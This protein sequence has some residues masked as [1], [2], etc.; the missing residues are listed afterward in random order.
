LEHYVWHIF[1][2]WKSIC[3]DP[4]LFNLLDGNT[5]KVL[6]TLTP[7]STS[8]RA[9]IEALAANGEIFS[10]VDRSTVLE[11]ILPRILQVRGRIPSFFTLFQDV[12][13]LE[14][15]VKSL[16]PLLPSSKVSFRQSFYHCFV[17][18]AQTQG[19]IKIQTEE[20]K[21]RFVQGETSL[22]KE[23]G[24]L[25]LFLAAMRDFPVLSQTAPHQSRGEKQPCKGSPEERQSSLAL[26]ALDLG[27]H[28]P[29]IQEFAER[30][31]DYTAIRALIHR[32]RP[33]EHYDIDIERAET[34]AWRLVEEIRSFSTARSICGNPEFS[35][36]SEVPKKLRCGLPDIVNHK[37]DRR[38]LFLDNM[39]GHYPPPR[40]HLTSLGF[41]RDIFVCFFGPHIIPVEASGGFSND[42]N[43]NQDE[44]YSPPAQP[45]TG[46]GY[47]DSAV[48][49]RE[50][51][52]RLSRFDCD[53]V[54]NINL[55][56]TSMAPAVE[57]RIVSQASSNYGTRSSSE[58]PSRPISEL[59]DYLQS[60]E[61]ALWP[62]SQILD[63]ATTNT[64]AGLAPGFEKSVNRKMNIFCTLEDDVIP[65]EAIRKFLLD[66]PLLVVYLWA[67]RKYIKFW[68]SQRWAFEE[69]MC[70]LADCGLCFALFESS[71]IVVTGLAGLWA[72]GQDLKLVLAG[73]KSTHAR[74]AARSVD[75]FLQR[76]D[77]LP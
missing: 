16:R 67:E 62:Y 49:G 51:E 33:V 76:I 34:C 75:D 68:L 42:D 63:D 36:Y 18:N 31:S 40:N 28:S 39:Y 48:E 13:Y 27:F 37:K 11:Q 53:D 50:H 71:E 24:Y 59:P 43:E 3:H 10:A 14:A 2:T 60:I 29:Q 38:H 19:I 73:P 21:F 52:H 66:P 32:L 47:S 15:C 54:I 45:D 5:V 41:Q 74:D 12:I 70:S 4:Q 26:L 61:A 25:M 17:D 46:R 56:R 23:L 8:D 35:G 22:R 7:D 9:A 1:E 77:R 65:S 20:S 55:N 6:E 58:L 69:V 57:S 72:A 30:D 64:D 44:S